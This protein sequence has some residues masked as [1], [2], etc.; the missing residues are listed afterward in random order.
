MLWFSGDL[1]SQ[2]DRAGRTEAPVLILGESGTGKEVVARA[3]HQRYGATRPFVPVDCGAITG[4]LME[5]ELFG[6]TRGAFT[7]A[8]KEKKGLVAEADNG[9]L[10]LDEIGE[11]APELQT[12]LLRLLQER[13]YRPV[14]STQYRTASFRPI[15]ATHRD[16]Q[17]LIT[18]GKFREDLY[19]RI[20]V[21]VM[22]L[23]PLRDRTEELP[24]LIDHFLRTHTPANQE[25][26]LMSSAVIDALMKH[27][28]R[29]NIRE[30][31]NV[32][33]RMVAESEGALISL[34]DLP[35]ELQ[36]AETWSSAESYAKWQ[37]PAAAA[38]APMSLEEMERRHILA[39]LKQ[40]GGDRT[41][42]AES[43]GISRTALWRKLKDYGEAAE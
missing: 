42:T 32:V 21:V 22:R 10:F 16:L 27:H 39:T 6:H 29:G 7:G 35:Q 13:S 25:P 18:E 30:L 1:R 31:G 20:A 2:I 8:D 33:H 24:G 36:L 15:F 14:G 17:K 5:S 43:L 28:W 23:L 9:T 38:A 19:Y 26:K 11:L 12:K 37:G 34:R 4:T 3:I 40:Y 41:R